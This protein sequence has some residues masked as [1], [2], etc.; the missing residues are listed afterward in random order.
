M[1][2]VDSQVHIWGADTPERP[3]AK[4]GTGGLH[5][6]WAEAEKH[7]VP[8]TLFPMDCY[9][10]LTKIL[11]RHPALRLCIDHMGCA[12]PQPG[13][14]TFEHI[15]DL[16]ALARFPNLAVKASALANC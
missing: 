8:V 13:S 14:A 16:L 11:E 2:I 4:A 9:R 7:G 6:L 12:G 15:P 3:W 1:L 10:L 5:W